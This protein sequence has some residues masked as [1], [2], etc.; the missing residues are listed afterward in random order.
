MWTFCRFQLNAATHLMDMS[1]IY[2]HENAQNAIKNSAKF[3]ESDLRN[4]I[5]A[6]DERVVMLPQLYSIVVVWINFHNLIADNLRL[7][8][9]NLHNETIF[10][11]ARRFVIAVYQS[12]WFNEVLPLIL[13]S[14]TLLEHEIISSKSCYDPSID[15]SVSSEFVAS[16]ARY[17]HNFIHDEYKVHFKNGSSEQIQLRKLFYFNTEDV[18]LMGVIAELLNTPWNTASVGSEMS[19][20]LFSTNAHGLDLRA[21][22]IQAERD[23]GV[24]SYCDALYYLN[25]TNGECVEGFQDIEGFISKT[26]S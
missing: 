15:P 24:A 14:K 6:G 22:D 21:L 7:I 2:N 9:P 17:F 12:V 18:D 26:V 5:L 16:A 20:Y 19:N 23:F 4:L 13:S 25:L 8:H 3:L 10:Y 1:F 11:E